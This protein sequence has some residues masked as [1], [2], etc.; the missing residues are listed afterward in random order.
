M[1]KV[2]KATV[3]ATGKQVEVYKLRSGGWC[4]YSDCKTVYKDE[5]L[6]F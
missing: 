5:E 6:K 4:D 1:S 3:K 2:V